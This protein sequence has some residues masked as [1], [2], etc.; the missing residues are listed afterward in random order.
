[1]SFPQIS[2]EDGRIELKVGAR[3]A[4]LLFEGKRILGFDVRIEETLSARTA[5]EM[6]ELDPARWLVAFHR[7]SRRARSLLREL[8]LSYASAAGEIYIH[9]SP[10]HVEV[11]ARRSSFPTPVGDRSS[12]FA[13]RASRIPRW[14]LLH[15]GEKP[16][17]GQL[18]DQL[19]LSPSVVS[20]TVH[21]L[22]EEAMVEISLNPADSRLRHVS[23]RQPRTLL[24]AFERST[25][26]RRIPRHTCDI[27]ARDPDTA[28]QQLRRSAERTDLPYAIGGL[29]GAALFAPAAEPADVDVWIRPGDLED[30]TGDMTAVAARPRPGTVTFRA[31][32]DPFVLSLAWERDGLSVADPVQLFLDCRL[33]GERAID[34]AEAIRGEM[35]W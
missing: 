11:P 35:S 27:G 13:I 29:A 30:W 23:L 12:A 19:D 32:P 26:R 20:R 2:T 21:A 22:A 3:R 18:G 6:A 15:P 25:A 31:L 4:W 10:V 33:A 34:A 1:M 14:L 9:L 16:T 17:F 24:D 7:S 8:G 5:E 28:A